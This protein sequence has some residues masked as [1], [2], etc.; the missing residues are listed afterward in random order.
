[1]AGAMLLDMAKLG[2]LIGPKGR[3]SNMLA[4]VRACEEGRVPA[5]VS[6]VVAPKPELP[7]LEALK[8]SGIAT[9]IVPSA[10][11]E[12]YGERLVLALEGVDWVCLAGFTRL[13][14]NEVLEQFPNHVLNIHP[15]LL[16]EFGGKGMFGH[17]LHEAVLASGRSESG[18]TVHLVNE[19]YD[20]GRILVQR[21]V[22]VLP[23]DSAETLAARVLVQ[24]HIAYVEALNLV[25]N[26]PA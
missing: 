23:G 14:P 18:C 21:K 20:E 11:Q 22:H 9:S 3:G 8:G 7:A 15:A 16:P 2:I 13:L 4:I 6:V 26:D 24:E 1:M 12:T 5:S 17:Y 25:L 19:A 10:P